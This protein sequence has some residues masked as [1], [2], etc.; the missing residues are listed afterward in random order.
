M[1]AISLQSGSNGN[2]IYVEAGDEKILFDAGISGIQAEKRLAAN[3]VDIRDVTALIISHDHSDHSRSAGI[4]GRKYGIPLVITEKTLR[5]AE[6]H[7]NLGRLCEVSHFTAGDTLQFGAS[8]EI[9]TIPTPHDAADGVAF[10]VESEGYRIGVLTDLGH[11]FDGLTDILANLDG[12]FLESNYEPE[13]LEKGPYPAFLK[14]RIAGPR[15]HISNYE[16]AELIAHAA[17]HKLEWAC[18][19]HLSEEN[20]TPQIALTTTQRKL[21]KRFPVH[22]AS[23]YEVGEVLQVRR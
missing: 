10:V 9:E 13:M 7:A 21:G 16:S 14:R 6:R 18:L 12:V 20:N 15:G 5:A 19:A 11:V 17:D 3:G 22:V 1:R 2:C 8:L 4:F 23:R